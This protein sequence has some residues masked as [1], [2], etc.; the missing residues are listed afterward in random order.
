MLLLDVNIL[1]YAQREDMTHH[2]AARQWLEDALDAD[3]PIGVFEPTLASFLRIV[4]NRR[5]FKT[6]TP[7]PLALAFVS[8]IRKAPAIRTVFQTV[9]VWNVFERLCRE[10]PAVGDDVPDAYLAAVAIAHDAELV[11]TDKGFARFAGLT[12]NRPF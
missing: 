10:T 4:T 12:W 1:V 2:A 3:Q 6:P 7:L 8:A 11:T 9:D 5:I